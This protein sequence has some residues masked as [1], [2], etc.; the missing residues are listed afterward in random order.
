VQPWT[1]RFG[2]FEVDTG[3]YELRRKGR[4]LRLA[5]QPMDLLL[6]LLEHPRA[7]VTREEIARRLWKPGV[8]T[9]VDA[10]IHTAILRIRRCS[11][12][13]PSRRVSSRRCRAGVT[14]SSAP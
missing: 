1:F 14:A 7:L 8:F 5:R 6:L 13:Q 3:G 4:R 12:I 2:D 11:V 10:G 9:D